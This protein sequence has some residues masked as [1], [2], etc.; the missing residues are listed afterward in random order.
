MRIA[1]RYTQ[2]QHKV[3]VAVCLREVQE[4]ARGC[5]GVVVDVKILERCK[6]AYIPARNH[7][8]F[9]CA[10]RKADFRG[11]RI[12]AHDFA[13]KLCRCIGIASNGIHSDIANGFHFV[14]C[15][16]CRNRDIPK[17]VRNG[18]A[19]VYG[20]VARGFILAHSL[21]GGTAKARSG[22]AFRLG[23]N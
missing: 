15:S 4:P 9:G 17:G 23:Q 6:H 5:I 22:G 18:N 12:V 3:D 8:A 21:D 2:V 10:V 20:R 14:R 13:G 7:S 16:V 11:K 1:N 19:A